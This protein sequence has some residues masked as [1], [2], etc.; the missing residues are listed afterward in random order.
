[1]ARISGEKPTRILL[2]NRNHTR[3]A[4]EVRA[5]TGA[6]VAIHPDDAA[7]ARDQGVGPDDDLRPG[8]R[9]G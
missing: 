7:H 8:D 3:A 2:T 9:V 1:M 5:R 4:G 6:R